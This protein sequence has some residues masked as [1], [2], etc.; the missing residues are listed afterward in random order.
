MREVG[1][2]KSWS[3]SVFPQGISH[4]PF[5]KPHAHAHAIS[6]IDLGVLFAM[7]GIWGACGGGF[8]WGDSFLGC[9]LVVMA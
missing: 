7:I 2:I 3:S 4:L 8:G 1:V 9:L 6:I 5:H